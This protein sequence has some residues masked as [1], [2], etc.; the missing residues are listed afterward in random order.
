MDTLVAPDTVHASLALPPGAML[1]G[2][3]VKDVIV[4]TGGEVTVTVAAAVTLPAAF[5]AVSV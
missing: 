2:V 1:P 3:A 4:G 5:V